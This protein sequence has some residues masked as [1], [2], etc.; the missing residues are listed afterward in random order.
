[1][2]GKPLAIAGLQFCCGTGDRQHG[3][4]FYFLHSAPFEPAAAFD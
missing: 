4:D 2:E 3:C 1:M